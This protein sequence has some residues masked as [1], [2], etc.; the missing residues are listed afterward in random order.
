M[1][2]KVLF[3]GILEIWKPSRCLTIGEEINE[4]GKIPHGNA[5]QAATENNI[6]KDC[7]R[8]WKLVKMFSEILNIG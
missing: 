5:M 7:S 2:I 6:H 4:F 1:F 3:Y 8:T